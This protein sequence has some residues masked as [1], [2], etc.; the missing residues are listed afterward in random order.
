MQNCG[1]VFRYAVAPG[2]AKRDPTYDLRGAL[3]PVKGSHF[4]AITKPEEVGAFLRMIEG[5]N[6]TPVV[7]AALKLAPLVFVR[8]GELRTANWADIDFEKAE[9]SYTVTKTETEHIVPLAHQAVEILKIF[10]L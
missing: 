5:Y 7:C 6:G 8:P 10:T 2:R 4:A 3:A 9:W 1:Q